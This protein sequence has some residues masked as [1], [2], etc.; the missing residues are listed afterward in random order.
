MFFKENPKA[1][2]RQA[3][4]ALHLDKNTVAHHVR[5]I[6]TILRAHG[7]E[8]ITYAKRGDKYRRFESVAEYFAAYRRAHGRWPTV[9]ALASGERAALNVVSRKFGGLRAAQVRAWGA[10]TPEERLSF[11]KTDNGRL[12]GETFEK[13]NGDKREARRVVFSAFNAGADVPTLLRAVRRCDDVEA[14][15]QMLAPFCDTLSARRCPQAD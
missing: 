10:L 12:N 9:E 4:Q 2:I 5:G 3:V 8:S 13:F 15:K 14:L 11:S 6:N 1:T 7:L